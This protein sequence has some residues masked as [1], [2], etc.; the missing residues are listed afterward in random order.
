MDNEA[1]VTREAE[2]TAH[3]ARVSALKEPRRRRREATVETEQ[4]KLATLRERV[5]QLLHR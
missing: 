3:K 2:R 1:I 5:R 4:A